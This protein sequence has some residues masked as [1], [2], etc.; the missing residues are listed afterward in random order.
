VCACPLSARSGSPTWAYTREKL[1]ARIGRRDALPLVIMNNTDKQKIKANDK[2]DQMADKAKEGVNKA[3]VGA[4]SMKDKASNL[5][6][7]AA[8][9]I[10]DAADKVGEKV[11]DA[12]VAVKDAGSHIKHK[13]ER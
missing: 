10:E 9:K 4:D 3:A 8:E 6:H 2:I 11:R 5:A 1:R 12:G 13:L 7:R